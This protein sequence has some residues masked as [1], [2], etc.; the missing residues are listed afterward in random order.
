MTISFHDRGDEM[1]GTREEHIVNERGEG[2]GSDYY[3]T[4]S[5]IS[6]FL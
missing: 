2:D 1:R 5:G 3:Q 6:I 4:G